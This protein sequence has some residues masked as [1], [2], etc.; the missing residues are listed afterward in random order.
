MNSYLGDEVYERLSSQVFNSLCVETGQ[1][2]G[3]RLPLRLTAAIKGPV[4]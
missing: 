4:L 1:V 2:V 3:L